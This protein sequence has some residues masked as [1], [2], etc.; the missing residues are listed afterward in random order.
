MKRD[1][2]AVGIKAMLKEIEAALDAPG[3]PSADRFSLVCVKL[4]RLY[5]LVDDWRICGRFCKT[6]R[7]R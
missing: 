2:H 3:L 7:R 6:R 5:Q 1:G 4:W